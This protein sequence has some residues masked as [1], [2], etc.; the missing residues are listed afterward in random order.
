MTEDLPNRRELITEEVGPFTVSVGFVDNLPCEVFICSRGKT[1]THLDMW[2]YE[3]GVVASR[4]MQ[5]CPDRNE[6]IQNQA[7]SA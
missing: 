6:H 5:E 2:L 3:M 7:H 1:G 4:I